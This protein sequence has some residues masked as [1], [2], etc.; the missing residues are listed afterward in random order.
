MQGRS[1]S[2]RIGRAFL[3]ALIL[4]WSAFPIYWAL[5]TSFTSVN[6]AETVPAHFL[7]SPFTAPNY[8]TL[9]TKVPAASATNSGAHS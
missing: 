5:N 7:P 8:G 6:G 2:R 3:V 9:L 1:G 4:V